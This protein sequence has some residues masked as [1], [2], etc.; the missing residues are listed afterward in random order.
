MLPL[1]CFLCVSRPTGRI[2][3]RQHLAEIALNVP[4]VGLNL[5]PAVRGHLLGEILLS[6]QR[7]ALF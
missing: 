7:R 3:S 1:I 6:F 4:Q 2:Q 5:I